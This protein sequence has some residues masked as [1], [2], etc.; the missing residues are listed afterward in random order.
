MVAGLF[1]GSRL[2]LG[3]QGTAGMEERRVLMGHPAEMPWLVL[4]KTHQGKPSTW[5]IQAGGFRA[6]FGVDALHTWLPRHIP[7]TPDPSLA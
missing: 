3:S 5:V 2:F 7:A 4:P 6:L 1:Q